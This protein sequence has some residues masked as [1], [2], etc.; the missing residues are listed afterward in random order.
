MIFKSCTLCV[1]MW[2]CYPPIMIMNFTK[3]DDNVGSEEEQC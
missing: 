2:C 1:F 3:E